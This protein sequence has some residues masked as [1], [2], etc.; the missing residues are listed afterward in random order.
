MELSLLCDQVCFLY[1]IDKNQGRVI[2]FASHAEENILD[3][4]NKEYTREFYTNDDVSIKNC[5][6]LYFRRDSRVKETMS[7]PDWIFLF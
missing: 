7:L 3:V 6:N 4:F 1:I 2:H 5:D